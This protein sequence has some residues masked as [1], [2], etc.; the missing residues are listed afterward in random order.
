[1]DLI[2]IKNLTMDYGEGPVLQNINLDVGKG[3]IVFLIG[4]SGCGKSTLLR[5]INRLITPVSGEILI[6][7]EDILRPDADID[8]IRRNMAMVFQSFNLFS[9]LNVIENLILAPMKVLNKPQDEAI[10]DAQELLK[11][12]GMAGREN[13]MPGKLSGGQKQRIAIARALAMHPDV[14]LFDEPTSALDPTMVDEVKA[15]ISD[16]CSEGQ[17]SVI[18]THDMSFARNTAT[19]VVFLAEKG[20]YEEGKPG[21]L[22]NDPKKPLTRRFLFH[23]RILERSLSSDSVDIYALASDIRRFITRFQYDN[24]HDRL[25]SII[26]DEFIYPIFNAGENTPRR[27]NM[28]L[29]CSE[30]SRSHSFLFSFPEL[31]INP[32]SEVFIDKL[33]LRLLKH[34]SSIL[35]SKKKE[36][37]GYE[38]YIQM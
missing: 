17:T 9:H 32:L 13:T 11:R 7:G 19:K 30:T 34:N 22:F 33:N 28:R 15:V 10:A 18:V 38:V 1:M 4:G 5:C 25:I 26:C 8:R 24:K 14:I 23:S 31:N 2:N 6:K 12:V 35:I 37:G 21:E 16:L 27:M 3:D 29:I 36:D 20:I